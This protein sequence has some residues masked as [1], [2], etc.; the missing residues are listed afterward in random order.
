MEFS[1]DRDWLGWN[2]LPDRRN[3]KYPKLHYYTGWS[4]PSPPALLTNCST[5]ELGY[6]GTCAL[7]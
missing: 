2:C 4:S 1:R 6:I 7:S 5:Q 3:V